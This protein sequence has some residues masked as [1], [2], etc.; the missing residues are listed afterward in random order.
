MGNRT[1]LGQAQDH[2]GENRSGQLDQPDLFLGWEGPSTNASL[3]RPR[4]RV[5]KWNSCKVERLKVVRLVQQ[6]MSNSRDN[7]PT[8]V[9]DHRIGR[10]R[11]RPQQKAYVP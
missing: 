4:S 1:A 11:Y 5:I 10:R 9:R 2:S 8:D 6:A 3:S 7:D